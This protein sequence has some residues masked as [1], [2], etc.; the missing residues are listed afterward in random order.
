M[1]R[2]VA[3]LGLV[4]TVACAAAPEA[5]PAAAPV[6]PSGPQ[7]VSGL[8]PHHHPIA[9]DSDEAQAF[10]DQGF[11]WV[12]AFNHDEATRS[13][14]RA[15]EL[16][17]KSPM[18]HW[19]IAWSLAP[20][21]N[22]D[23]DD[24]RSVQASQA[25]ARA[26][27]LAAE[28]P[29]NERD[30][31]AAMAVRFSPDPKADR[32]KLA[33]AYAAKM[34]ELAQRYPDDLD[35]AALYA[36][37]LMNIAPWQLY[38]SDSKPAKDTEE[39]VRVLESVLR[40]DPN[41]VGA[42]HYYIHAVEA[43]RSPERALASAERLN[44]LAP[45]AGHLVHMPAHIYARTGDHAAAARANEA[46]A[47][48]DRTYMADASV[49]QDG[50]YALAYVSHN[51]HFLVDDEMMRGRFASAQRAA[52]EVV[53]RIDPHVAMMPIM[54]SMIIAPESV[55]MRFDRHAELLALPDAPA[56]RPVVGAWR[57]FA[58]GVAHA[59]QGNAEGA[60]TERAKLVAAIRALPDG[61]LFGGTGL[62]NA[63]TVLSLATTVLDARIAW[64]RGDQAKS[65]EL[66]KRAVATADKLPYE[67]PPVWFY[68]VRESLGGALLASGRAREAER[69][70][71]DDL[72]HHP[73]NARSLFGLHKSLVSQK[74]DADAAWV[75]RQF[76]AAWS[77]ADP[78]VVLSI[79]SL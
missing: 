41:H 9:T 45:A 3:L 58:R 36:E 55:L 33:R 50:F 34:R 70:F 18:P 7:L 27:E 24:E 12:F 44:T 35:A 1:R 74:R 59:K 54:E 19:G 56:D 23:I 11:A 69:V 53:E 31:V 6:K 62:A 68:P 37:S 42:N 76:E 66:W 21:Y 78:G 63:N 60:E 71:R 72:V 65:V 26:K 22:L 17:P 10:F 43:S 61:A 30:Y 32:K 47:A 46:G 40:R 77:D 64:A 79:E 51:L 4:C 67:E 5:R 2:E 48:A 75:E 38:T 73:R 14:E 25:M 49:P 8:A 28:A 52:A 16:D 13:F 15:A 57:M 20:N 39:I 29:Q